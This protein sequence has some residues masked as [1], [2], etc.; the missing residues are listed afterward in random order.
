ME[1]REGRLG[2]VR[3]SAEDGCDRDG[4]ECPK[5]GLGSFGKPGA[6]RI[7]RLRTE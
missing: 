5:M 2:V 1:V 7:G 4:V 3:L 6:Q